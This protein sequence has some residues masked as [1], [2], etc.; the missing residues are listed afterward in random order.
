MKPINAV[1]IALLGAVATFAVQ[2]AYF[3][4]QA[5]A[6][7]FAVPNGPDWRQ[8]I[9]DRDPG[10]AAVDH[11]LAH[12]E[13]TLVLTADQVKKARP[14]LEQRH[15]RILALLLTAPPTLTRQQFMADARHITAATHAKLDALLTDDQRVLAQELHADHSK[16]G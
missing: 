11:A 16:A 5:H 2:N 13:G 1:I 9:L 10:S 3:P 8:Q 7:P 14:L 6:A 12:L 4:P 15:Q